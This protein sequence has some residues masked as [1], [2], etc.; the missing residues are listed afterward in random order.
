MKAFTSELRVISF[1]PFISFLIR[2]LC[3][4]LFYFSANFLQSSVFGAA[5]RYRSAVDEH[6]R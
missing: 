4:N 5:Y 3:P 6:R 1:K 2:F